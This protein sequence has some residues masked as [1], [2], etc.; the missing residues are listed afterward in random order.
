MAKRLVTFD[1]LLVRYMDPFSVHCWAVTEKTL[2]CNLQCKMQMHRCNDANATLAVSGQRAKALK[3]VLIV[4]EQMTSERFL[5][6]S[7]LHVRTYDVHN[8]G[9]DINGVLIRTSQV[10]RHGV[11]LLSMASSL[12]K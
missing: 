12:G 10:S 8:A 7:S 6:T 5:T 9:A 4:R 1:E 3:R 2:A 11:V